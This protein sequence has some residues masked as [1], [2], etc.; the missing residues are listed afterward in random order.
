MSQPGHVLRRLRK[1]RCLTLQRV[2]SRSGLSASFISQ[3]ER[4]V[5]SI[6]LASL[7]KLCSA[8]EVS[9]LDVLSEEQKRVPRVSVASPIIR[10]GEGFQVRL[11]DNPITYEHLTIKFPKKDFE[12][13]THVI[14][15]GHRSDVRTHAGDEFGYVLRGKLI[16]QVEEQKYELSVGDAYQIHGGDPHGFGA[17]AESD[18]EVLVVSARQFIEWYEKAGLSGSSHP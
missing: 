18:A 13:I 4:G 17:P 3:V 5:C 16:L 9:L 10:K 1:D 8:L 12:V 15:A 11:G 7:E 6:S 14:P 2:S